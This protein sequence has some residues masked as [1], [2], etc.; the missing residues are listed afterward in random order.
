MP[1]NPD[2]VKRLRERR[3]WTQEQLA[4]R[5]GVHRVTIARLET[6]ALRPGVD[7]LE[8]LATALGVIAGDLLRG[9]NTGGRRMTEAE[10]V[11]GNV[12]VI[13]AYLA[14]SFEGTVAGPWQPPRHGGQAFRVG[15]RGV[16]AVW[17]SDEFL[18]DTSP[19]EISGV[20][21]NWNIGSRMRTLGKGRVL[22][23]LSTG[24]EARDGSEF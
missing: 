4:E 11:D 23:V 22:A 3:G 18:E 16:A 7:L 19:S 5:V 8:S 21:N 14:G 10:R 12:I 1:W 2:T 6:G 20:L 17:F 9:H 24:P 15:D 13:K